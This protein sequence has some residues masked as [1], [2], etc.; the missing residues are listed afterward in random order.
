MKENILRYLITP[1][2]L[3]RLK[4]LIKPLEIMY[5]EFTAL[6]AEYTYKCRFNGSVVYLET[7]LNDRFDSINR[8][9]Y[10]TLANHAKLYIYKVSELKPPLILYRKWNA[11]TSFATG[12]FCFYQ[13]DIYEAN[14]TALN[15][16]PGVDPEWDIRPARKAPILRKKANYNGL[17]AFY[18][19]VPAA[20]VFAEWE[21]KSLINYYKLAG[22]GYQIIIY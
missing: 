2:R 21:M 22:R 12:K 20:V 7:A 19:Y 18:V 9:I 10:I 8:G 16:V 1:I 15:K 13:G 6:R 4:A 17:V 11:A 5:A 3:N 14:A